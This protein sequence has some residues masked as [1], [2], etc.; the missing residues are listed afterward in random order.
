VPPLSGSYR[1]PLPER[2]LAAFAADKQTVRFRPKP[3]LFYSPHPNPR[4]GWF[5][6]FARWI[7]M[8]GMLKP[9]P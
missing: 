8:H 4:T 7:G 9:A 5:D 3:A 6:A 1:P 2:P